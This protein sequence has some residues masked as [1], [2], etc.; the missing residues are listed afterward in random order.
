[1]V[2]FPTERIEIALRG[3]DTIG[4]PYFVV[5]AFTP[6]AETPG[7]ELR[8]IGA[9]RLRT[10]LQTG[11]PLLGRV[12]L[13]SGNQLLGEQFLIYRDF[14]AYQLRL[15]LQVADGPLRAGAL[16]FDGREFQAGGTGMCGRDLP[17]LRF[18]IV[19]LPLR[20]MNVI[21]QSRLRHHRDQVARVDM[22]ACNRA[23]FDYLAGAEGDDILHAAR[24]DHHSLAVGLSGHASDV[25]PGRGRSQQ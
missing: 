12:D 20:R 3:G 4:G 16:L 7:V 18:Q 17:L 19:N 6:G 21:E 1:M 23:H 24:P 15:G 25:A 5:P 10:G 9:F 11:E 8:Y 2:Q 14:I 22:S 13:L